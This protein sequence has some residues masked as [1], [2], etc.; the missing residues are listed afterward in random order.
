MPTTIRQLEPVPSTWPPSPSGLSAAAAALDPAALW[1][2]IES[3]IARRYTARQVIWTVEG[4][5]EWL[6]PLSPASIT[7]VEFWNGS[8]WT[9]STAVASPLGGLSFDSEG[10]WRVT[11]NVG[12]GAMPAAVSEAYRRLAEYLAAERKSGGPAPGASRFTEKLGDISLE[13]ER[14]PTWSARALVN[15][16]AADLLRSYRSA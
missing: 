16:G 5:G 13:T 11:A 1:L 12:G 3:Y 8:A 7:T 9:A 4:S 14:A 10:P 15:S 6:P 2:R